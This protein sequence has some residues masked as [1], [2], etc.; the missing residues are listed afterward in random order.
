MKP[1]LNAMLLAALATLGACA[2]PPATTITEAPGAQQANA[3]VV[4]RREYPTA[5]GVAVRR[6]RT[7]AEIEKEADEAKATGRR[8]LDQVNLPPKRE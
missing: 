7:K 4:C 6:C 3:D 8:V 2:N 5:S 1:I